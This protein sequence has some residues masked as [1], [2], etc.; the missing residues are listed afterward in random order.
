MLVRPRSRGQPPVEVACP[1]RR[2]DRRRD[3]LAVGQVVR[4]PALPA[5][6]VPG[7]QRHG[8]VE[9]EQRRPPARPGQPHPPSA[10]RRAADDPQVAAVVADEAARVVDEAAAVAGE[11]PRSGTA[12]SAPN[13]STRFGSGTPPSCPRHAVRQSQT[14]VGVGAARARRRAAAAGGGRARR[15][16]SGRGPPPRCGRPARVGVGEVGPQRIGVVGVEPAEAEP[17]ELLRHRE[18]ADRDRPAVQRGLDERQPEPLP[19][20]RH[21]DDVARGVGA[22]H[23]HAERQPS[24]VGHAAAREERVELGLVAVL[25][26]AGEP[27]GAADGGGE[28][29]PHVDALARDGPRRL[30]DQR[31]VAD[32]EP[33]PHRRAPPRAGAFGEAVVDRG[34][35]DAAADGEGVAG[36]LVDRDVPPGRVVGRPAREVGV[37]GGVPTAGRGG[38]ARRDGRAGSRPAPRR[39]RGSSAASRCCRRRRGRR[40]RAPGPAPG[41]TAGAGTPTPARGPARPACRHPRPCAPACRACAARASIAPR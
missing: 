14:V 32:L 10:E 19:R 26:R 31:L 25:G 9:E 20:R 16:R 29:E 1:L 2:A 30:Q 40:R 6:P 11:P 17:G 27:V 21:R 23:P 37:R 3:G 15:C 7:G 22:G 18:R 35:G 8:V 13:G 4:V 39:P 36:E 5:R 34:G 12:C 33:S 24:P 28:G 38:A 41:A